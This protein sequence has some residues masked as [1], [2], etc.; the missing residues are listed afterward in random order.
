MPHSVNPEEKEQGSGFC[1]LCCI[2][3]C[4]NE[5]QDDEDSLTQRLIAEPIDTLPVN[6]Q[7]FAGQIRRHRHEDG[8]LRYR[9]EEDQS[10]IQ[11]LTSDKEV[12]EKELEEMRTRL[13]AVI[14]AQVT[15][16]NPNIA[17]LSDKN[18]PT[19]LAE[20]YSELYDNQW[21]EC[22]EGLTK[23]LKW[24]NKETITWILGLFV[25]IFQTCEEKASSS[26]DQLRKILKEFQGTPETLKTLKD[27]RKKSSM[28]PNEQLMAELHGR[29]RE[30][31]QAI[32][33]AEK[34]I[35]ESVDL[36][37]LMA[38]QDPP[39][40]VDTSVNKHGQPLDTNLYKYYT[41]KGKLVDYVVWPVLFL[42]RD[43]PLLSKGIAQGLVEQLQNEDKQIEDNAQ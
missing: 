16:S 43:G 42:T 3:F 6:R 1:F 19:K 34:F 24:K 22:Y 38:V 21:T 33:L 39:V 28:V 25:N 36:C 17:D 27:S 12:L 32:E 13:S 31:K 40:Y 18:R 23:T 9:I 29:F 37:W 30:N 5:Y 10:H 41:Q 20:R 11:A 8:D 35:N 14:S 26:L 15:D 4:T 2:R 7:P